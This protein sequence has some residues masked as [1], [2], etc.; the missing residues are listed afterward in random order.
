MDEA[1]KHAEMDH[2]DVATKHTEQAIELIRVPKS[3]R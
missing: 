1:I 2:A 3:R